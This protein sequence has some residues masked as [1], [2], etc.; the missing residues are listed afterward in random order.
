MKLK[1]RRQLYRLRHELGAPGMAAM[2]LFAAAIL[3]P[4]ASILRMPPQRMNGLCGG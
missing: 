3:L 2:L 4:S 1:I